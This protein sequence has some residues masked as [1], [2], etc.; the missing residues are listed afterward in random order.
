VR[1]FRTVGVFVL[2]LGAVAGSYLG[3]ARTPAKPDPVGLSVES[4]TATPSSSPTMDQAHMEALA[5]AHAKAA[6]A[7]ADAAA[8]AKKA[9]DI[10]ARQEQAASRSE[11]RTSYPVPASCN[12]YEGNRALGCALMLAAGF[13][14][15]QMPCLERMWTKES[16]WNPRSENKSSGA[17]GIPQA[18]PASK[19]AT[20][21][22]DY[23]TNPV[24]QIKWGLNYIKNR[25]KTPC[26]AWSFWQAHH[27]Y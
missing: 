2:V 5:R 14:L 6:A 3:F 21:G 15:D 10:A 22:A 7:A 23:R 26:G 20:Y 19:M 1:V 12:D 16:G 17:Y 13:K 11:T 27:W 18:L 8:R 25:Y 9:N 4:L 24:P